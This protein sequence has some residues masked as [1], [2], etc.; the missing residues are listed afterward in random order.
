MEMS[1]IIRKFNSQ[2]RYRAHVQSSLKAAYP[3]LAEICKI[4]FS[5]RIRPTFME[6][7]HGKVSGMPVFQ[8]FSRG[9]S[10]VRQKISRP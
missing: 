4:K 9:M 2:R 3:I 6:Q 7:R 5:G 1:P 10:Q 8:G